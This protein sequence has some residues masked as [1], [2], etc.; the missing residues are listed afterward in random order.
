MAKLNELNDSSHGSAHVV[1]IYE[2]E[3]TNGVFDHSQLSFMRET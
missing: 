3:R 1:V 2:G